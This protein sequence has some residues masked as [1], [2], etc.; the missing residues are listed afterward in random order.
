M[1]KL[2]ELKAKQQA[3]QQEAQQKQQTA[4]STS[5][6]SSSTS[7]KEPEAQNNP[8]GFALKRQPSKELA[9]TRRQK[10]KE[11]V[12][13]LQGSARKEKKKKNNAAELR[14]HKGIVRKYIL[15]NTIFINY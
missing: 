8:T 5:T 11:N 13:S 6:D 15:K 2:K 4:A 1:L 14:V 9:D 7:S 3:Q 12:F 10:S